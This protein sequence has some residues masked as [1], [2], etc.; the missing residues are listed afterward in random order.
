MV[1]A[2]CLLRGET[3]IHILIS[4]VSFGASSAFVS[5][6]A[7][8]AFAAAVLGTRAFAVAVVSALLR[9][10]TPHAFAV[11]ALAQAAAYERRAVTS[12][13]LELQ[14]FVFPVVVAAA[15]VALAANL[16]RVPVAF[17]VAALAVAGVAVALAVAAATAPAVILEL[18][19]L[20]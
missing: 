5:Y 14:G 4:A 2:I 7:P 6:G 18:Y 8:S 15:C 20:Q 16:G 19:Q 9:T 17:A 3:S 13:F 10:K 11:A 1:A 12:T